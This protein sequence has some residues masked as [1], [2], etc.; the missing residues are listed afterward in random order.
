MVMNEACNGEP[1]IER[2]NTKQIATGS[3][4]ALLFLDPAHTTILFSKYPVLGPEK[5]GFDDSRQDIN[6]LHV[7][8][9]GATAPFVVQLT[10][11]TDG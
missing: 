6:V 4:L 8:H 1:V 5:G 2:P 10:T 7:R 3:P 9:D 11:A